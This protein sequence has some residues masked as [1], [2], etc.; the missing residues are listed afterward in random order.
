MKLNRHEPKYYHKVKSVLVLAG[1]IFWLISYT[2]AL[3]LV[4]NVVDP[5]DNPVAGFRWLIEEDTTHPVTPGLPVSDSLSVSIHR[6]YAPIA[7]TNGGI[8]ATGDTTASSIEVDISNQNRYA[9]SIL[10]HTGYGLG[11]ANIAA[12]QDIVTVTVNPLPTRT[13]QISVLV[14]RDNHP[15][16]NIPDMPQ[17]TGL[18]GYSVQVS[19]A[20][21]QLATDAFGNPL[22]TTYQVDAD[23]NVNLNPDGTPAILTMGTGTILTDAAGEALVKFLAPGRYGLRAT[24]PAGQ[25]WQQTNTIE[26]TPTIDVWVKANEPA[27]FGEFGPPNKHVFFGFVQ[28]FN[29]LPAAG[30]TGSI[31]GR[32]VNAHN[33]APPDFTFEPGNPLPDCWIGLNDAASRLGVYAAPCEADSTFTIS[34]VPPGDYELAVWDAYMDQI[35]A[36]FGVTVPPTGGEAQLCEVPGPAGV[37]DLPVFRWFGRMESLIFFDTNQN[38][39]RD[40]GDFGMPD[41]AVSLRFRDGSLYQSFTSNQDGE[42]VFEEIFPFMKYLVAEVD[43]ARFKATGATFV[44]DGGGPVD[45]DM[46]WDYPSR[47]KLTPQPQYCTEADANAG[48]VADAGIDGIVGTGDDVL[49]TYNPALALD[50]QPPIINPNTGNNLSRTETGLVLT[51]AKQ[52]FIGLTDVIEWGKAAYAP[53]ENGGISGIIYY[54]TTRAEDDPRYAAVE[55]WEPGI[56]RIQVNLYEDANDD[57]IIDDLNGNGPR[58]ADVDNYPFGWSTGGARGDEDI[59]HNGNGTYDAG[60][61]VQ[62]VWSDSWDDNMPTGCQAEPFSV[63]GEQVQDCFEGLRTFN[64]MRP[65]VFDGGYAFD[66]YHP[67]GIVSGSPEATLIPGSYIV[68]AAL[69]PGYEHVKEEDK[70]VDFGDDYTPSPLLLPP[71]CVGDTR[72]V[73]GELTLFPGIPAPFAGEMRP[74]CDRKQIDLH[75][76]ANAAVDFFMFTDVPKAARMVGFLLND[77]ANVFDPTHPFFGEKAPPPWMPVSIQDYTG[78]E[79]VRTYSDEYGVY[80][81]LLPSTYTTNVPSPTGVSPNIFRICLNDPGPIPNPDNP[82]MLIT[83][84]QFDPNFSQLCYNFDFWPGKTSYLDTPII[85]VASTAGRIDFPLDCELPDQTPAIYSVEGPVGGPYVSGPGQTITIT[86]PTFAGPVMVLNP[87]FEGGGTEPQLIGRDYGFGPL[88]IPSGTVTIGGVPLTIASWG[89]NVITATV[90]AGVTTGQLVVTRGDN[91]K[92]TVAGVTVTVGG[93]APIHVTIGGSIQAA[94]DP[95]PPGSLILVPPGTYDDLVVMWKDVNLQGWGPHSTIIDAI[96]AAPDKLIAWQSKIAGLIPGSDFDFIPGQVALSNLE[97]GPGILVLGKNGSFGP[98]RIDGFTI[99]GASEGG[100][101]FVNGYAP[102]LQISNNRLLRNQGTFGGGI[103]IGHPYL[104]DGAGGFVYADAFNDG[105]QIHHNE[106]A[107]NGTV[108]AAGGGIAFYTGSDGYQVTENFICGNF[109]ATDG[110]GIGHLGLSDGGLISDNTIVFNQVFQQT[111]GAGG[112]GGGIVIA[113]GVPL[114]GAGSLSPGSGSVQV[115]SNLIQGNQAGADDGSGILLRY[116]NGQDTANPPALQYEVDIYNNFIVN[117]VTGL[118][119]ALTLQDAIKVNIV[120]NT[121]AR[122]DS[123]ATAA[124]AFSGGP[125]VSNP[126]PAGVVARVHTPAL[127]TA[128][129][130]GSAFSDPVLINNI[131]WQNRSF[132]WDVAV[133]GGM[134]G[135]LPDIAAGDPAVYDDLAVL[136]TAGTLNPLNCLVTNTTDDPLFVAEYVNGGPSYLLKAGPY[137]NIQTIPAF[138]EGGNFIDM[139]YGPMTLNDPGTGALFG[140]YHIQS[141]SSAM[142]AG[143]NVIVSLTPELGSDIDG[144]PRP[145]GPDVDIGADEYVGIAPLDACPSDLNNDGIVNFAD[146]ALL[147]ANFFTDCS[148]LPPGEVCVGDINGDGAVNFVDLAILKADM[149]TTCP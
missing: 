94:I 66:T 51:H 105:I 80:N 149:F 49:C 44:V 115:L 31:N 9:I 1:L 34:D 136:G 93:P 131:I 4:I 100:G 106:L 96:K 42:V 109:S 71:V 79:I 87:A 102:N 146:L 89:P 16:N 50:Q 32:V 147:K 84:P 130:A 19:D 125:S 38:G 6:S 20:A 85:P 25:G 112:A 62:I 28:P 70:N 126:H 24:P 7:M 14:F 127:A 69:P 12:N 2:P 83:D 101:I 129:G 11:G 21:G 29:N 40:A 92:S 48:T 57:G 114:G 113:G 91:G 138:D 46:G 63:H 60:D 41:Q 135:L 128:L 5:D 81:A 13:A 103:R 56:P 95:A 78:K 10:P 133:G 27:V 15:I 33:S 58:L 18:A 61:A 104:S 52:T 140:D 54:A 111:A 73:P 134:G 82:E 143:D 8:A 68:E 123:L 37:C 117:N 121:I 132:Y 88:T 139:A 108:K 64:Q 3:A 67:G 86:A 74:V 110:G 75:S 142:G 30:T 122:N 144:D 124:A 72:P 116:V 17:E 97:E 98:A 65:G 23:G 53:D 55:S 119:G 76:G 148:T 22:G 59:D 35:F 141:G 145:T 137:T 39:F 118:A 47:G 36:I 90:P 77:L 107:F 26:G 45:P 43:F 99:T 120:N